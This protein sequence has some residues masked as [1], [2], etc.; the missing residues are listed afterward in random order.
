MI[1]NHMRTLK[2]GTRTS[3]LARW[4]T[5]YV[6]RLLEAAWPGLTCE[7]EPFVTQGDRTLQQSLPE[8]GGKGLFT[9]ELERALLEGQIDIAV[10]S[11]KDLP[12][13]DAPG[14]TIGAIPAR[15]DA[16]DVL[17]ARHRHTLETLPSGAVV[18]TSSPR[19]QAQLL[20]LRPD[21]Q[22]RPIR[23]NVGTRV[24]K[25]LNGLDGYDAAIL[26]AAGLIRL[27]MEDVISDWLPLDAMLPAPGQA[28]LAVQCRADDAATLALLSAIEDEAARRTTLAERAFLDELG[29]GCSAPIAAYASQLNAEGRILLRGLVASPDGLDVFRVSGTGTEPTLLA[30]WLAEKARSQGAIR[31][32]SQLPAEP[33]LPDRPL[34]GQRIV[35]TR[36]RPQAPGLVQRL[37]E[38]GAQPILYPTI[39]IEPMEDTGPLDEAIGRLANG[40]YDRVIFTSVNGV[41]IF[42]ERLEALG[43]DVFIFNDVP[44]AAIGPATGEALREHGVE[45]DFI[46]D[47]YVAEAVAAG[48]GD[49]WGKRILLPRAAIA[50][51]TLR[52]HLGARGALVDEVPT[53]RTLAAQP[54]AVP[55]SVLES[56]D[57]FT[58]TSSSTVRSFVKLVGGP[59]VAQRLTGDALVACIGPVTAETARELGM[60]PV[61]VAEEYTMEGLT[62]AL[63]AHLTQ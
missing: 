25:V 44:V 61:I 7:V 42:W 8:I 12:V 40:E 52:E 50:R 53:Y 5:D 15:G 58:F 24:R 59:A 33:E 9:A 4:Q 57:V 11:L 20:A 56:A 6:I 18:G 60:H 26:A 46:P 45:P 28:A 51:P 37:K 13:E 21:L 62:N 22:V 30:R 47:E 34:E 55:L 39:S 27:D 38:L 36:P 63:V 1:P 19:R 32:L 41:A 10:H 31:V 49:V 14:L 16:H 54:N 17:V 29:G 23:G 43:H 2:V 48:L 35:V 3:R